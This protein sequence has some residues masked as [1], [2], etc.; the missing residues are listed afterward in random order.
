MKPRSGSADSGGEIGA[1]RWDLAPIYPSFD[2]EEYAADKARLEKAVAAFLKKAGDSG[3]AKSK[4]AG[5]LKSCLKKINEVSDLEENLSAYAY[6]QYSANTNDRQ[7]L[8]E[9]NNLEEIALPY[10]EGMVRFRNSVAAIGK[11][12]EKLEAKSKTIKRFHFFLREQLHYAEHQMS[13]REEALAADL[14]RAGGEAW[15]RLQES[16]SS[17]LT[18]EWEDGQRKTVN[19]LRSL[20]HDGDRSVREKAF[21][22]ELSVWKQEEIALAAAI[23]GVKG[24]TVILNRRR[25]Y[26]SSLERA[27]RQARVG[28]KTLNALVESMEE[29]L[30]QFR[31]YLDV[32]ARL[33]GIPKL[34]FYDLFAPVGSSEQQWSFEQARRFIVEQFNTFSWDLGE[35]AEQAFDESWIDAEM[36]KGKIGGAYCISFPLA[37]ETRVLANFD[38]SFSSV[39]TIAHEL[40]HGYHHHVLKDEPALHRDYPMTL[41]E[42]ASIFCEAIV[43]NKALETA[44]E[45]DKLAI[46]ESSLQDATQVIVDILSRYKFEQMVFAKRGKAELA[47]EELCD[48]MK[49]AQRQTYGDGLAEETLHPYMWAVKPHYYRPELSFYNFPYAFGQLF[50]LGLFAQYQDQPTSFPERYRELLQITGRASAEEVTNQ[51]GFDIESKEFWKSGLDSIGERIAEL[52]KLAEDSGQAL[53]SDR[54]PVG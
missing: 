21:N 27:R 54:D 30:P 41:A 49:D 38:G 46:L 6:A 17:N 52:K 23:N 51:A 8:A 22:A 4:P 28:E 25:N 20:A 1:P 3:A 36:R 32:K 42:T 35:F 43:F 9:L 34:A 5:W 29:S 53:S 50:G 26:E 11:K 19:E 45:G 12:L 24:F 10:H 47:P 44:R 18:A 31:D 13:P 7:A 33:L 16:V 39:S 14:N 2:S 15:S 48:M 40:G 37:R